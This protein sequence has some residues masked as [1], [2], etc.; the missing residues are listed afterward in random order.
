MRAGSVS[1]AAFGVVLLS[2]NMAQAACS[3]SNG[4]GWSK[5]NGAGKFEM[6]AADKECRIGF[7]NFINDE[8]KTSIPATTVAITRAPKSGKV[9]VTSKEI[10]YTPEQGFK[11][12]DSFC[13]KNTSDKV[14][15]SVLSGCI[16]VVV[17]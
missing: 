11:G 13:T 7:T 14:K 8:N 5:G 16:T 17:R 10:V 3:G 9:A 4:R 6:S 2:M 12:S 1:I 15:G